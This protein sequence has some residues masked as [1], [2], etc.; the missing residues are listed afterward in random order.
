M[1]FDSPI[2]SCLVFDNA[3]RRERSF[4]CL[5]AACSPWDE[6]LSSVLTNRISVLAYWCAYIASIMLLLFL[7]SPFR[8]FAEAG[9]FYPQGHEQGDH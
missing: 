5:V 1:F 8:G 7:F 2:D 9:R 6:A 3:S 4:K